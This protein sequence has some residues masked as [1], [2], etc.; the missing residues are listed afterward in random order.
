MLGTVSKH[1]STLECWNLLLVTIVGSFPF[2][3]KICRAGTTEKIFSRSLKSFSS[4]FSDFLQSRSFCYENK[5]GF[6][7]LDV[8]VRILSSTKF[9]LSLLIRFI[10]QSVIVIQLYMKG[11]PKWPKQIRAWVNFEMG[12]QSR[13]EK[14]FFSR[15]NID[16]LSSDDTFLM[17]NV[18]PS[19]SHCGFHVATESNV[20]VHNFSPFCMSSSSTLSS[21]G[22]NL[23]YVI[24]FFFCEQNENF[25][26]SGTDEAESVKL[27]PG[28]LDS[29]RGVDFQIEF[30]LQLA[31]LLCKA[32]AGRHAPAFLNLQIEVNCVHRCNWFLL[33]HS[34]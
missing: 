12:F 22:G 31:E 2:G 6:C 25:T 33:L 9:N 17:R 32:N 16:S 34:R 10:A 14:S 7:P 24:G 5:L 20:D 27:L 19:R 29:L 1:K 13:Q 21:S 8:S 18:F 3:S 15:K 30:V 11:V 26:G 28:Y 23:H 4:F